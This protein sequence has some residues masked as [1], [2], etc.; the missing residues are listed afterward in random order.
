MQGASG[1]GFP[2]RKGHSRNNSDPFTSSTNSMAE[3]DDLG[4]YAQGRASKASVIT[5]A[6]EYED[7]YELSESPPQ[8]RLNPLLRTPSASN[9]DRLNIPD[10]I[11]EGKVSRKPYILDLGKITV[12]KYVRKLSY[13]SVLQL[14]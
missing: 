11:Q 2:L 1:S 8:S 10:T 13:L 3:S 5:I 7:G 14:M 9:R 4:F 6:E 12:L